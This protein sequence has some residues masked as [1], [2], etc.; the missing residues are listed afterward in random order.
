MQSEPTAGSYLVGVI[1]YILMWKPKGIDGGLN[2]INLDLNV[3][4][5]GLNGGISGVFDGGLTGVN[6]GSNGINGGLKQSEPTAGSYM[7]GTIY[8]ILIT[9]LC[10]FLMLG[11]LVA[12][13]HSPENPTPE[14]GASLKRPGTH[15]KSSWYTR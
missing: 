12:V 3:T 11:I 2:G 5:R 6:G 13:A 7:V 14:P 8:Y 9:L 10:T 4:N 15:Y 1:Y